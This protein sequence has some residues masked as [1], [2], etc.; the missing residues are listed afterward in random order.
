M[1]PLKAYELIPNQ[2]Y[3]EIGE[4][5]KL[6]FKDL[7]EFRNDVEESI[8]QISESFKNIVLKRGQ[9]VGSDIHS[10]IGGRFF[11]IRVSVLPLK[12][13]GELTILELSKEEYDKSLETHKNK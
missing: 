1:K 5:L 10:Q 13:E 3:V 8:S 11:F 4:S 6:N 2:T 7:A 12:K 9:A